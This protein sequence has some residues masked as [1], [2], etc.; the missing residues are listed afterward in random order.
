[1]EMEMAMAAGILSHRQGTKIST[2]FTSYLIYLAR[3]PRAKTSSKSWVHLVGQS[4]NYGNPNPISRIKEA[5]NFHLAPSTTPSIF[6]NLS[7]TFLS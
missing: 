5:I 1:M 4:R 2:Y 3:V 7:P 6:A